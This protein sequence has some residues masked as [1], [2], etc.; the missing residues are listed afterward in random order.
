LSRG[1]VVASFN[2]QQVALEE[3]L[4]KKPKIMF[5][6]KENPDPKSKEVKEKSGHEIPKRKHPAKVQGNEAAE[7][8]PKELQGLATT[9]SSIGLVPRDKFEAAI[10]GLQE[11]KT[12]KNDKGEEVPFDGETKEVF[13][14]FSKQAYPI[15]EKTLN[16]VYETG[17]FLFEVREALKPKKLFL[18]WLEFTGFRDRRY[19]RY[20]RVYGSFGDKLGQFSHL[21]IRKLEAASSLKNCVEYLEQNPEDAEKQTVGQFEQTIRKLRAG[22]KKSGRGRKPTYETIGGCKVR[23]SRD[24][25]RI[26][27]EGLSKQKQSA[28][29]AAIK[30]ALSNRKVQS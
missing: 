29:F 23:Q 24:G 28:L 25:T 2:R 4:V 9:Q 10:R 16:T 1:T 3:H 8:L 6:N 30:A 13:I 12:I 11:S 15:A 17:R 5:F 7:M 21:G 20:L 26:V 22:K 18:R 19:Y 14:G 27:I